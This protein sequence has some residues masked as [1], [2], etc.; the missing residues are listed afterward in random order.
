MG[1]FLTGIVCFLTLLAVNGFAQIL[2]PLESYPYYHSGPD[3]GRRHLRTHAEGDTL[4]LPFFEDF[5][6]YTGNPSARNWQSGGGVYVS[7]QFGVDPPS[8]QVAT[9]DGVNGQGMPYSTFTTYDYTDTLPPSLSRWRA[10][11]RP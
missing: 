7:N 3:S 10:S 2:S 9:F 4:Q 8:L 1:K 11:T 5:A 6:A